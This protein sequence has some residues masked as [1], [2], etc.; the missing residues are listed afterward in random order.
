MLC[1]VADRARVDAIGE[2]GLVDFITPSVPHVLAVP[3]SLTVEEEAV[4]IN[5]SAVTSRA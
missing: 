4:P 5:P 2:C 1:A 3:V